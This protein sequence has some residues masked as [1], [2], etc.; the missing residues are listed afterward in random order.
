MRLIHRCAAALL[1][2]ACLVLVA[3]GRV[4]QAPRYF[5][6]LDAPAAASLSG[7][8]GDVP[9]TAALVSEGRAHDADGGLSL[10]CDFTLTYLSPSALA[11]VRVNYT[12]AT[13]D[14]SVTLGQLHAQ[15]VDYAALAAPALLLLT[16]SAVKTSAKQADGTLVLTTADGATRLLSTDGVP[17][18]LHCLSD[19]R[20]VEVQVSWGRT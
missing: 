9:F 8:L 2:A 17:L 3:C 19:G 16:E 7:K 10:A 15:G 11:G 4:A 1:A 18:S 6:Y 12:A 14:V 20:R 13:D 5:A